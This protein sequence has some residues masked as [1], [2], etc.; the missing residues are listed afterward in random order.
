MGIPSRSRIRGNGDHVP[1]NDRFKAVYPALFRASIVAAAVAHGIL[2]WWSP[3]LD[4]LPGWVASVGEMALTPPVETTPVPD[5]P[6]Y[7]PPP[8]LDFTADPRFAEIPTP[9][10]PLASNVP[11]LP[12]D[13]LLRELTDGPTFTPYEIAP[14]L[15]NRSVVVDA[16]RRLYPYDS[17]GVPH[18]IRAVL[19]FLID[20]RGIVRRTLIK[21]SSG[22]PVVDDAVRE[23]ANLMEFTPAW[24][25]DRSVP[26]WI[27]LPL[28]F[29]IQPDRAG[30]VDTTVITAAG[31]ARRLGDGARARPPD[32]ARSP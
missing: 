32:A 8:V 11:E 17:P 28:V 29:R 2:F 12:A 7:V 9:A 27:V 1:A 20:E 19:W 22:H 10:E 26:V 14:E 6:P 13:D 3:G 4:G 18:H 21:E 23:V 16:L 31:P 30:A 15:Q 24:S 5:P 25:G